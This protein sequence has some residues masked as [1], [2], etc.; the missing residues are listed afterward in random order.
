[1]HQFPYL[2]NKLKSEQTVDKLEGA[3]GL[4]TLLSGE[5]PPIK[6]AIR[7]GAADEFIRLAQTSECPQLQLESIHALANISSGTMQDCGYLIDRNCISILARILREYRMPAMELCIWFFGN[8]ACEFVTYRNM[9][10]EAGLMPNLTQILNSFQ[11][12][13][14][15]EYAAWAI[16]NLCRGS[17]L[18]TYDQV[19]EGVEALCRVLA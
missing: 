19:G 13:Q 4:R 6:R 10:L 8:I 1:M 15:T 7:Q 11:D 18:P 9:L 16:S 17:P 5:K 12:R 14:I 2:I 3:L